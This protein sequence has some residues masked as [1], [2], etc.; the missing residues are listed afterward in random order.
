M[1]YASVCSGVEAASLAW[2]P[3]GWRP[4]WFAEVEPFPSAVLMHRFGATR[5]LRPL[6]PNDASSDK[7]RKTR[8]S[9]M[10]Q[11]AAMP[12]TGSIPNLGD[13]TLIKD[14][15]YDKNIDLL[16]GG[17]P[18]QSFSVAGLRKGLTDARG[19]LSLEFVKLA[20]NSNAAGSSLKTWSA[21][22]APE[23]SEEA[24]LPDSYR[25]CAD[26]K[27]SHHLTVGADPA[28]S[29]LPPTASAWHGG[30]L[31]LNT[32]EF[33]NFQGRSRSEGDVSSLSDILVAG[34]VPQKYYLTVKC[35]E[36]ILRRAARRGKTL[37]PVL[38]VALRM[39]VEA[40][41]VSM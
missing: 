27:S 34:N 26:G 40:R 16:V 7:D 30:Y 5:P 10:R 9:W 35:A 1:R 25:L 11:I 24:I 31:T 36:G 6:D 12:E 38:E 29:N 28:S 17:C 23:A 19:N 37:P 2:E 18:C 4:A 14:S 41:S 20:Y 8:E 32:P 3:L 21:Y 22:S 39:T 33:P 15:D 13:F